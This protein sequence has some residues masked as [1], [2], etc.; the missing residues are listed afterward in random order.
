MK[1][2]PCLILRKLAGC[3]PITLTFYAENL[4]KN[5]SV[6][7]E[8]SQKSGVRLFKQAHLFGE[9][10]YLSLTCIFLPILSVYTQ[11]SLNTLF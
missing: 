9:I 1:P 4:N 7:S 10:R 11:V 3:I 8:L 2:Y 5:S 6:V